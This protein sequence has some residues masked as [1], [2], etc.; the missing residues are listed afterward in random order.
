MSARATRSASLV[1]PVVLAGTFMA[2]LDVAIVNV[3][4]PSIRKDLPASF[5]SVEL[6]IAAYTLTYAC[7]LV[8]GGRL[9]D[10]YGRRRLFMIGLVA[11]SAASAVCGAAPTVGVLI[12]ARAL[13]GITG[14]LMYPQVLAIIQVTYHGK[15]GSGG[16]ASSGRSSG[17]QRW[18]GNSSSAC[19]WRLIRSG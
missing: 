9:G 8:T 7:L 17:S 11:F 2:F 12:A 19:C 16:W 1:L 18:S 13:Q 10:L 15:S 3:A 4:I 5:G 14:A 6:V